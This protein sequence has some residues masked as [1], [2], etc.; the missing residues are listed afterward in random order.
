V[1]LRVRRDPTTFAV[2]DDCPVACIWAEA[3]QVAHDPTQ[4]PDVDA[5]VASL[6]PGLLEAGWWEMAIYLAWPG[7][8]LPFASYHLEALA[9]WASIEPG[10]APDPL[11]AAWPRGAGKSS[12]TAACLA[13]AI[14]V[15]LRP[16]MLWLSD[17]E[18]QVADKVT[19]VGT[20][21]QAKRLKLAFPQAT[22]RWVDP[23]TGMQVDWRKGRIRT[24]N[25]CT[26]DAAGMDKALRGRLVLFDRPGL[27][28]VD[29]YEDTTDTAYMRNKRQT[30]L[31][32]SILPM[33]APDAAVLMLE[34][35]MHPDSLQSQLVD[36][37][38]DWLQG[39]RVSGPWPQIRDMETEIE[40]MEDGSTRVVIAG[41][42]PTWPEGRGIEV[43]ESQIRRMGAAS[44]RSEHNH[45]AVE[46]EGFYFERKAFRYAGP[47]DMPS[48]GVTVCRAWDLAASAGKGDYTAGVLLGLEP[49]GDVWIMD[50]ARG[51][52]GA[53]EVEELLVET[54]A[55]DSQRYGRRL[56]WTAIEQEPGSAGKARAEQLRVLLAPHPV[57]IVPSQGDKEYRAAGLSAVQLRGAVTLAPGEWRAAYVDEMTLFPFG[58]HDDQVDG[59]SLAYNVLAPTLRR[60][61]GSVASAARRTIAS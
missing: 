28:V 5:A 55:A 1:A 49:G 32:A 14:C 39:R 25:G 24:G 7:Q 22:A 38:A 47:G 2:A 46:A 8:F 18:D 61:K 58:A 53:D 26:L 3:V 57:K 12:L 54:A 20:L 15:K 48:L 36:G 21:L 35:L 42:T 29:D 44:F 56:K 30:Q 34:N 13:L 33:G 17:I 6:L 52:L 40:T 50:V 9:W 23:A 51:Q 43:S 41:G 27:I 11:V 4:V 60:S 16:F 19:S 31:T 10:V 45:E 37:R 59:S